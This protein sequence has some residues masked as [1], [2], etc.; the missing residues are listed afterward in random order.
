MLAPPL[1]E[2]SS[3]AFVW[4]SSLSDMMAQCWCILGSWVGSSSAVHMHPLEQVCCFATENRVVKNRWL[5][6]ILKLVRQ[7]TTFTAMCVCVS[8]DL[9]QGFFV[10]CLLWKI[11]DCRCW[12]LVH[13]LVGFA[14]CVWQIWTQSDRLCFACRA[15]TE[16]TPV[17][18]ATALSPTSH[19]N[20][21]QDVRCV[22]SL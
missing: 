20:Q 6:I 19:D 13:W 7:Q 10:A 3:H 16:R 18:L 4:A 15:Q 17:L 12:K 5:A 21:W 14:W 22:G 1:V 2:D 11:V 8:M 9:S